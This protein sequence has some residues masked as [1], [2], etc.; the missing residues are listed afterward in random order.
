[1]SDSE[2]LLA[3]LDAHGKA[4]LASFDLPAVPANGKRKRG[5]EDSKRKRVEEGGKRKR[6]QRSQEEEAENEWEEWNGIDGGEDVD[7]DNGARRNED[8]VGEDEDGASDE[9]S[10]HEDSGDE[11]DDLASDDDMNDDDDLNDDEFTS[12]AQPIVV[13]FTDPSASAMKPLSKAFMSS[14]VSKLRTDGPAASTSSNPGSAVANA[15]ADDDRTNAQNDALLHRLVHTQLLD[16]N[17]DTTSAA[18]AR[19]IALAGRLHELASASGA[20]SKTTIRQARPGAGTR[21]VLAAERNK[22]AKAVREGL[23]RKQRELAGKRLE[24]AKELG[25]YHPSV[26]RMFDA[27]ADIKPEGQGVRKRE[28]GMKMGVGSFKGGVLKL[29]REDI[30]RVEGGGRGG[31]RGGGRG[32]REG[33]RGGREGSRGGRGGGG[34]E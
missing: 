34:R 23:V 29:S 21:V 25:T 2:D 13:T 9:D 8:Q 1:M 17:L 26:K 33:G 22:H 4:F 20:S 5:E 18:S 7:D 11:D 32:S 28:R 16:P 12:A 19:R 30:A 6:A 3:A 24:E 14:K 10:G 15:D 27:E 31:S